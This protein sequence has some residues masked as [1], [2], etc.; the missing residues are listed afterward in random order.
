MGAGSDDMAESEREPWR[1]MFLRG[2]QGDCAPGRMQADLCFEL[3][4]ADSALLA[5]WLG[6]AAV[7]AEV[8]ADGVIVRARENRVFRAADVEKVVREWMQAHSV[9][10]LLAS[11][12]E[13]LFV[14]AASGTENGKA[15]A[16]GRARGRRAAL[17]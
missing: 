13:A 4:A 3:P 1:N 7:S 14:L 11:S 5:Q 6:R 8:D 9:D 10:A 12:N 16:S 15:R 17:S 2:N